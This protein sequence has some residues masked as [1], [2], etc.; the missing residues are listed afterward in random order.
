M[1]WTRAQHVAFAR[2]QADAENSPRWADADVVTLLGLVHRREWRALLDVNPDLRVAE[3]SVTADTSARIAK[4]ALA[5]GSGD[6]AEVLYKVRQ[7]RNGT[8]IYTQ[9][10]PIDMLAA[11]SGQGGGTGAWWES[12]SYLQLLPGDAGTALT[13]VVS[14]APPAADVLSADTV[15]VEWPEGHELVLVY[16]TAALLLAKGGT[17]TQ[18]AADL[19][20]LA[21]E[22]RDR[23][24]ADLARVSTRPTAWRYG[25][26]SGDWGGS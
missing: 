1:T 20:A 19:R 11:T 17:E 2:K 5:S 3:R 25:D 22:Q 18:Q 23:M 9:A 8:T 16:E 6:S 7:V 24:Y 21:S 26:T 13:V 10:A 12:G 15:A 14:H 4:T